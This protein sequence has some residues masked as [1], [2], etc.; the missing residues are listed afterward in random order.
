MDGKARVHYLKIKPEYFQAVID[1]RKPFE[2]RLNDRKFRVGDEI[3][4][5]EFDGCNYFLECEHLGSCSLWE[6]VLDDCPDYG[7]D[8]V[9]DLCKQKRLR[10][11]E[12][13]EYKYT[14]RYCKLRIKEIFKLA[15]INSELAD[16]VAFTFEDLEVFDEH[17]YIEVEEIPY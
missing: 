11:G 4:L 3:Y 9:L 13:K 14:G 7:E 6:E 15:G 16:F 5:K 17:E 10:C 2:I 8:E 1:G 12:Y